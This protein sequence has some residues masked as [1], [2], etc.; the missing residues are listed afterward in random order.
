M[1]VIRFENRS[2]NPTF[3]VCVVAF[4]ERSFGD[5]PRGPLFLS[6]KKAPSAN[7]GLLA[8]GAHS[9]K[10]KFFCV[11]DVVCLSCRRT[12]TFYNSILLLPSTYS[13]CKLYVALTRRCLECGGRTE[14]FKLSELTCCLFPRCN[15]IPAQPTTECDWWSLSFA[16]GQSVNSVPLCTVHAPALFSPSLGQQGGKNARRVKA[17]WIDSP[18][19][20]NLIEKGFVVFKE[21]FSRRWP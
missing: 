1:E 9:E 3:S 8:I 11:F 5:P 13:N 6:L 18:S 16:S 2:D 14:I 19:S 4:L 17:S 10:F 21:P 12:D 15:G 20:F 7:T